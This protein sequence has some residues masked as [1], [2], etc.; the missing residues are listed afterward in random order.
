EM[1]Y[2]AWTLPVLYAAT[3]QTQLFDSQAY[4]KPR[5]PN[6]RLQPL[7]GMIEGYA[8]HFVGRRREIQRLLPALRD[9]SKQAVLLTGIGGAGK[10]TLATRLARKLESD[11]FMPI[12]ISSTEH[13]PLSSAQLLQTCGDAFLKKNLVAEVAVL[14]NPELSVPQ[15]LRYVIN[16]LN[17]HRFVLVLDN[18]EVNLDETTRRIINPEVAE[19]YS[20]LLSNLVG[21]SRALITCRYLPADAR[22]PSTAHEEALGDFPEAQFIKLLLRE[23][24]LE[25][26]YYAGNL[27]QSLLRQL[28]ELLGGTPRFLLQMREAIKAM[29]TTELWRE[30]EQV[31]LPAE[32]A[33]GTLQTLRE[34]YCQK[35]FTA[36]LFGYLSEDSQRALCR[37]A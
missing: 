14:N 28:H 11:G 1:G 34:E 12:A 24:E 35:I 31:R 36:R 19:F 32:S 15:R 6:L 17:E 22:L 29:T 16:T 4:E 30:L 2:P 27:P 33:P 18:F 10:S 21:D 13:N 25:K 37:S 7:P 26:R 5:R 9:G 23:P 3:S 8:E 20:H